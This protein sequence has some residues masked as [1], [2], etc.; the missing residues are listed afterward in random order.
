MA[1]FLIPHGSF[2]GDY[3]PFI[4]HYQGLRIAF[5]AIAGTIIT[6]YNKSVKHHG[7]F[8]IFVTLALEFGRIVYGF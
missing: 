4:S 2:P 5:P 7:I 3:W 1:L 6:R 8:Q